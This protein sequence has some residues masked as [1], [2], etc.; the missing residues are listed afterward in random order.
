M[1]TPQAIIAD[2]L[3][4]T[5]LHT[6]NATPEQLFPLLCPVREADWIPGWT[7]RLVHSGSGLAEPRALFCTGS[8]DKETVWYTVAHEPSR[9]VR[10]VR[11][12]PDGLLVDVDITLAAHGTSG[13]SMWVVYTFYAVN[14]EGRQ[15]LKAVDDTFWQEMMSRWKTLLGSYLAQHITQ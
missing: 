2:H 15:A 11:W 4:H 1:Q 3:V 6:F 13:T 7:A 8:S 12:Q 5:H 9:Y 14:A 10:F